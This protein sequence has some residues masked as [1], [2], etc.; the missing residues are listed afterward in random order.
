VVVEHTAASGK[1]FC[2]PRSHPATGTLTFHTVPTSGNTTVAALRAE[3][4]SGEYGI[5]EPSGAHVPIEELDV[6]VVPAL[7]FDRGGFRLGWGGGYYDR[8]LATLDENV[9]TAVVGYD[10]QLVDELPREPHDQPV[11][12]VITPSGAMPAM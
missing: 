7:A 12:W 10:W 2:L 6:V 5:L 3:L 1:R 9:T 4:V 8:M 11:Q